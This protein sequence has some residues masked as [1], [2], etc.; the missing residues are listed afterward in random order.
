MD[1]YAFLV[2]LAHQCL[3]MIIHSQSPSGQLT[4]FNSFGAMVPPVGPI[5]SRSKF[6][7]P[8][9]NLGII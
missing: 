1:I 6:L 5:P 4:S 2:N 9:D 3:P 8:E 7:D